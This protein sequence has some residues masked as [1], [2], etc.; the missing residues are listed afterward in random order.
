MLR[1][2]TVLGCYAVSTDKQL[3]TFRWILVLLS[4]MLSRPTFLN[5]H[6]RWTHLP[7]DTALKPR[8]LTIILHFYCSFYDDVSLTIQHHYD[9]WIP[10]L[11]GSKKCGRIPLRNHPGGR[12]P[13]NISVRLASAATEIRTGDL[14]STNLDTRG[15]ITLLCP[16]I[17]RESSISCF[18]D[19]LFHLVE[20]WDCGLLKWNSM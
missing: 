20:N 4:S 5:W 6:W 9:W 8:I 19:E 7:H 2:A 1:K 10:N 15:C 13:P 16:S 18:V 14:L 3:L 17:V 11:K 12:K